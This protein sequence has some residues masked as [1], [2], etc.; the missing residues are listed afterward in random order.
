MWEFGLQ[1]QRGCCVEV[2]SAVE[3]ELWARACLNQTQLRKTNS[4]NG[5]ADAT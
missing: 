4:M 2:G 1:Q 3:L 5:K